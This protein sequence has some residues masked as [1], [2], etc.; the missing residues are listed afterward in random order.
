[1]RG[2]LRMRQPLYGEHNYTH[3]RNIQVRSHSGSL[4]MRQPL[5]GEHNYTHEQNIQVRSLDRITAQA[6]ASL[7]QAQ[8]HP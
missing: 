3:E 4:R 2:L 1:M 8:L 6:S 5:Y 7:W